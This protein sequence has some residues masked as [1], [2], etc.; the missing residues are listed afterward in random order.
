VNNRSLNRPPRLDNFK[1]NPLT[2][3]KAGAIQ[4]IESKKG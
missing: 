3:K 4:K 2:K 1:I